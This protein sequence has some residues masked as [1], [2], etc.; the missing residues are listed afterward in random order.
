MRHFNCAEIM[1]G[2]LQ[3]KPLMVTESS[4][5]T[6]W[7]ATFNTIAGRLTELSYFLS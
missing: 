4:S 5:R 2:L 6:R 3:W 7:L 1:R